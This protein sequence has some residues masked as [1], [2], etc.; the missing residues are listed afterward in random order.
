MTSSPRGPAGK[1]L[2]PDVRLLRGYLIAAGFSLLFLV[3]SAYQSAATLLSRLGETD[4]MKAASGGAVSGQ[5]GREIA[6]FIAAQIVLHLGFAALAWALACASIVVWPAAKAKFGRTVVAWFCLL[7]GATI[8]YSALWFPRTLIGAYYHDAVAAP[9]GSLA[10]GQVIYIGVLVAAA[11]VLSMAALV[12]LRRVRFGVTRR[13]LLFGVPVVALGIAAALWPAMRSKAMP[14]AGQRRPNVII[15]GIDSLRLDNLKRFGGDAAVTPNLDRFL[16][17][18][19]VVKDTTTPVARTFPSWVAILTGRSPPVTGTRFNLADRKT[20][21]VNPT[22][23]DVLRKAG[24]RTVYST[25]EVRFANIDQSYGFDQV[26][27]PPIGAS[28]FLIGSYNELPLASVVINTRLG[29]A[30]FPFSYANRG[31]ATMFQPRTYL[32]R[33]DRELSFDGP[34]LFI[35]HLTAS[36]W[37]YYTSGVPFGVSEKKYPDDRPMYRIGLQTADSMFGQLVGLLRSKGAFDNAV[38]IVLSDHGEALAL[39]NDAYVRDGTI[40]EGLRAPLKMM[41]SGHGQS[42]LSPTQYH[43]LLGFR[44]F[45]PNRLFE[46]D[47]RDLRA[48]STVE[49]ISPT[50]LDLLHVP[51]DPLAATGK[52]LVPELRSGVVQQPP[53]A[54]DRIRY[55][56]TDLSVLPAPDGGVDEV[57]TARQNSKFFEVDPKTSRLHIRRRLAPLAL[58]YKERA[59][60]TRDHI[61]AAMPAGPDAHQY[62]YMDTHTGT[63]RL[64]RARPGD[65]SVEAQRLWDGLSAYYGSELKPAVSTTRDDWTIIGKQWDDFL[66]TRD[67]RE[68]ARVH[69]SP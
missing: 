56:E 61:L 7:A 28:D 69:A 46:A 34:T 38:V 5:I 22:V 57:A 12:R 33:L 26:I 62:I 17:Q 49:D 4:V 45:G 25:D 11:G 1:G 32:S 52:S 43:V 21:A 42:V 53:G 31:V 14:D 54:D 10:V 50:I 47:G 66:K 18:A 30:L 67:A 48:A 27:T 51:G 37:P 19:D 29:Q 68:A 36:H 23:A 39:P 3:G 55:T 40:I 41:D 9:V 13:V 8:I 20:I 44:T 35:A 64:L 24:Y 58:A 15:L 2:L 16:A 59:A 6:Y 65:E 60:F 63:G